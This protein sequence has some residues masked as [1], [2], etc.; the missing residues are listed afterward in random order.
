MVIMW[1]TFSDPGQS[2]VKYG[3]DCKNLAVEES[4][5]STQLNSGGRIQYIHS[6]TLKYLMPSTFYCEHG[7][8][9]ETMWATIGFSDS[10]FHANL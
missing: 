4:G 3:V 5:S 7:F 8:K 2:I 1:S 9:A 6:V 10:F